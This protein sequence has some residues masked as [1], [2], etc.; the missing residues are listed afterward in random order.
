MGFL[1]VKNFCQHRNTRQSLHTHKPVNALKNQIK[2]LHYSWVLASFEGPGG[3]QERNQ[4]KCS[5]GPECMCFFTEEFKHIF[6]VL[7]RAAEDLCTVFPLPL[8][9]NPIFSPA[10]F[11]QQQSFTQ[12]WHIFS[13]YYCSHQSRN[14]EHSQVWSLFSSST[15]KSSLFTNGSVMWTNWLFSAIL[16][17]IF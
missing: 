14:K 10:A 8:R 15:N 6:N 13:V 17:L 9:Q 4:L 2:L 11:L 1:C 7:K 3:S 5:T 12:R 16:V